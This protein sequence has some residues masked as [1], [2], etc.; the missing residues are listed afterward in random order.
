MGILTRFTLRTLARNRARTLATIIGIALS[1]TLVT[2][3][4]TTVTSMGGGLLQHRLEADGSWQ[5]T[6]PR[7]SEA[8]LAQLANNSH[9]TDLAVGRELGSAQLSGDLANTLGTFLTVKIGRAHV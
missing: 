4:F 1:C 2:A 9:V 6:S 3:I 8:K 7:V 5:V